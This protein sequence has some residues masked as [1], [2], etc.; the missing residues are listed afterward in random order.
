MVDVEMQLKSFEDFF[1]SSPMHFYLPFRLQ[2]PAGE[3]GKRKS[4]A[5]GQRA[6]RTT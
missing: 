5:Q 1:F 6:A 4:A 3:E 2:G